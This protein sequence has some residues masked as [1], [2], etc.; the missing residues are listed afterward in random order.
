MGTNFSVQISFG[1]EGTEPIILFVAGVIAFESTIRKKAIGV[2]SGI[3]ILYTLNLIRIVIL[4]FVG[5]NDVDLFI[6][7]HDIYLQIV[8]ILIAISMLLYW[9]NYAK[10]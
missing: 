3:V 5:G 2:L 4:F 9:I 8:L 1:C 6:A 10:K 7:L